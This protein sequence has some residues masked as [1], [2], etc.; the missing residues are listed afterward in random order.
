MQINHALNNL[1]AF[2]GINH[3]SALT[4]EKLKY[5]YF[6]ISKNIS[7]FRSCVQFSVTLV[8]VETNTLN[9]E[10]VEI[11]IVC[12]ADTCAGKDLFGFQIR[13]HGGVSP[14]FKI[15]NCKFSSHQLVKYIEILTGPNFF[16]SDS[17][18]WILKFEFVMACVD[19]QTEPKQENYWSA[20]QKLEVK[21]RKWQMPIT[22]FTNNF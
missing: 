10:S 11:P 13:P 1:S 2:I 16:L 12:H 21:T 4:D 17:L 3:Y 19:K 15:G 6:W 9:S 5:I 22:L 14:S 7:T 8:A 18:E 20:P